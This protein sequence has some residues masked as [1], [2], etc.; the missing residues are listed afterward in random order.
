MGRVTDKVKKIDC[1]IVIWTIF[2]CSVLFRFIISLNC[3][4]FVTFFDELLHWDVAKNFTRGQLAFRGGPASRFDWL[5]SFCISWTHL[6]G[7][8]DVAYKITLF[9]N[10]VMMSS[11]VFP[12]YLFTKNMDF[13][14]SQTMLCA[15]ISVMIPEMTYSCAIL[16]ENLLY[17][18]SMW[19]FVFFVYY[20]SS[21]KKIRNSFFMAGI[22]ILLYLVKESALSFCI[23]IF[24]YFIIKI[25]F[26]K[27]NRIQ[28]ILSSIIY[29]GVFVVVWFIYRK[30]IIQLTFIPGAIDANAALN[31]GLSNLLQIKVLLKLVY[32]VMIYLIAIV[33]YSGIFPFA[34]VATNYDR[35][36]KKEKEVVLLDL[37]ALIT[38]IGVVC[39]TILTTENLG[40]LDMRIHY[41]YMFYLT[42]PILFLFVKVTE[43]IEFKKNYNMFFFL[44]G[45]LLLMN[46]ARISPLTIS[47]GIDAVSAEWLRLFKGE[48]L[49]TTLSMAIIFFVVVLVWI[50]FNK[51][52]KAFMCCWLICVFC[53]STVAS[54]KGY[55]FP[56]I[57]KKGCVEYKAEILEIN[58]YLRVAETDDTVVI[59]GENDN[60]TFF[61]ESYLER[62]YGFI[63][64]NGLSQMLN[65]NTF[66]GALLTGGFHYYNWEK[67][68]PTYII[69]TR[70]LPIHGYDEVDL[71]MEI[72]HL[73]KRN[74]ET[75]DWSDYLIKDNVSVDGW[76]DKTGTV[77]FLAQ[78]E[79]ERIKVSMVIDSAFEKKQD[80]SY[81][82]GRGN[83]KELVLQPGRN[84]Y[85]FEVEKI[86]EG[87][88]FIM[89]LSTKKS[90]SLG[91]RD[92]S[93]R[94]IEVTHQ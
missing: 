48:F 78:E 5:Y 32:P 76:V 18:I 51:G 4:E 75:F 66:K 11:V 44:V 77:R 54:I 27:E 58:R 22:A 71:G 83:K 26:D 34:N 74:E 62:P 60:K 64:E 38:Y 47:S 29:F 10:A 50:G 39:V 69:A 35:L 84:T 43:E 55:S 1:R 33:T 23:G 67:E 52:T 79:E 87:N 40:Q 37:S 82:D 81:E 80:L 90:V 45:Y 57:T 91:D 13:K 72:C 92:V 30:F 20:I 46:Y 36:K 6:F 3:A 65:A 19:V 8:V 31:R 9:L 94:L 56:Y 28:N 73:Y 16:Q 93:F 42:L 85:Q 24:L 86:D 63:T 7:D 17:P 14:K 68:D 2:I 12:V 61:I 21:E 15:V 89:T 88:A 59:L 25:V 53:V 49:K 70:E 41:R